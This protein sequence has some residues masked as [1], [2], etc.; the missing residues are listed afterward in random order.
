M[1]LQSGITA[2]VRLALDSI[3]L[4]TL[5]QRLAFE[6]KACEDLVETLVDCAEV[7]VDFLAENAAEVSDV[8][9]V[10]SY[11]DVVRGCRCEQEALQDVM[12][13]GTIEYELDRAVDRLIWHYHYYAESVL[14]RAE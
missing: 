4:L 7:Q 5:D 11:E 2:E 3:L 14:L 8:M 1:S 10:N 13:F 6:L 12:P 9:L